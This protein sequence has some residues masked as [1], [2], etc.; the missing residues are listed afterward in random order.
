MNN[1]HAVPSEDRDRIVAAAQ[2]L[3]DYW[4]HIDTVTLHGT[5]DGGGSHWE[6]GEVRCH[7]SNGRILRATAEQIYSEEGVDEDLQ[8]VF[9]EA[10]EA[11]GVVGAVAQT[12]EAAEPWLALVDVREAP[13]LMW[14]TTTVTPI[15][16]DQYEEVPVL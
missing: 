6:L 12:F 16:Y 9:E 4:G 13:R 5:A 10:A 14:R 3:A 2:K 8:A 1:Q 7:H 15:D 11:T